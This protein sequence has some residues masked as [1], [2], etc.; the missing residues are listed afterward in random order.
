ML[1][2]TKTGTVLWALD[3]FIPEK[4]GLGLMFKKNRDKEFDDGTDR[5]VG[6]LKALAAQPAP[7]DPAK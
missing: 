5:I 2:D 6:D 3:E 4:P 1:L 7:A